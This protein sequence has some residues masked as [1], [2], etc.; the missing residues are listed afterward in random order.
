MAVST[1]FSGRRGL[2]VASL[3]ALLALAEPA[4]AATAVQN[5]YIANYLDNSVSVID[6]ATNTVTA[7]IAMPGTSPEGVAVTPDGSKVLV[8]LRTGNSSEGNFGSIAVIDTASNTVTAQIG[9]AISPAGIVVSPDGKT[10]YFV[11]N[12]NN[13][14]PDLWVLDLTTN[15]VTNKILVNVW[16]FTLAITPDGKKL[17]VVSSDFSPA[18]QVVD[19]TTNTPTASISVGNF[20]EGVGITPDGSQVYVANYDDNT[21]SVIATAT[22]TVTGTV[23]VG[24]A[25]FLLTVTPGGGAVW[26]ANSG[27]TTISVIDTATNKVT[28]TIPG[29]SVPGGI[30]FTP[31]GKTAYVADFGTSTTAQNLVSVIDVATQAITGTIEVGKGPS[32]IGNFIGPAPATAPGPSL[33]SATLPGSRSVDVS[34]PATV[35]ATMLNLT[36]NALSNCLVALPG[37]AASS[38]T[39]SYQTTNPATNAPTGTTNT[40]ASIAANGSQT[41]LLSFSS[42]S[43]LTAPGLAPV[44]RCDTVAAAPT[45]EGVNT[46]DLLFSATPIPDIIALAAT[47]TPGVVTVPFS[48]NGA[49]AFALATDNFG[50]D[51]TLTVKTDTGG[52]TLPLAVT[53]CQTNAQGAC[54][55]P[56]AST[57]TLDFAANATPTFSFFVTASN[58]IPFNPGASRIFVRFVDAGGTSH[59]ST[60]VAV[61]TD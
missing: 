47:A 31:D 19:L 61:D 39:L 57:V 60:S 25:P 38:L 22:N 20:P 52:A 32:P 44:Y 23:P 2:L 34:N 51:G 30:G 55:A 58:S 6:T 18:V 14:S 54:L 59:G 43:A 29:G 53:M 21:V 4:A 37:D 16:P 26:V 15:T 12:N 33:L 45:T 27:D 36:S 5:A 9:A 48:Q 7:T 17:Y 49:A 10:A 35:F 3:T 13:P 50:V 40:P 24:S 11:N 56:P 1:A 8:G 28:A 46:V 41:F 42:S